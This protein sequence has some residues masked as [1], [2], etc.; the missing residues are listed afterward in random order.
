VNVVLEFVEN[1]SLL[2]TLKNFGNALPEHL[3]ASY[4]YRILQGLAYLHERD[5]VHCDLK[6]ANILTTKAGDVK[7]SDFG[8]SLNLKLKND[9][10][11]ISGTPYWSKVFY[12]PSF[13]RFFYFYIVINQLI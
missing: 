7:L 8:V 12:P 3:V 13:E 6:A 2:N 11:V 9:D 4:C 1:G 5:V 10:N